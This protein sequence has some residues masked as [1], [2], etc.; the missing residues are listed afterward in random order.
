MVEI[1]AE[2]GINANGNIDIAKKLIGVAY[3]AGCDYVKFQKRTLEACYTKEELDTPRISPW[4]TTTRD[5]KIGIEFKISEYK[6]INEYCKNRIPWFASPWDT[7]SIFL[8]NQLGSKFIKVPSALLTNDKYLEI[9]SRHDLPVILSTGMS[10]FRMI[11]HAIEILGKD[12]IYA[13]L[14]CTS[15]YPSLPEEQ[16]LRCINVMKIRYPWTKIGFSNHFPGIP[17]M[18]AAV[19]LGAEMI[20][21]HITLDRTM[22]GS[23]Q[24][25]SLEPHAVFKVV[26]YIRGIEK[27]IGDGEKVI[28]D[29]ELPI[30]AKLRR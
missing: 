3:V 1:I 6:E 5:Q 20:E 2:I 26:K 17:F 29:S 27:A 16:N 19:G 30:I 15:T 13:I 24:A 22:Y 28:Y 9:V 23:D 25:S 21:F 7:K 8:I 4:G 11:D 10:T 12:R 14:H 18:A